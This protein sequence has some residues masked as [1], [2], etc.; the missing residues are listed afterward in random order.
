MTEIVGKRDR[1]GKILVERQTA[2][3]GPGDLRHLEGMGHAG[4][5]MVAVH[6]GEDLR[7][8]HQAAEGP[9]MKNAVAVSLV[10]AAIT[11][12]LFGEAAATARRLVCGIG[13]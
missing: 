11:G 4:A 5:V 6:R 1:L 3:D 7:L 2:C 10:L 8:V 13:C 12:R 9:A